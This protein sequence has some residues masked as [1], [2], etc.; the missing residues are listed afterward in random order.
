VAGQIIGLPEMS[1][2]DVVLTN[3]QIA[4]KEGMEIIH[5]KGIR[6]VDSKIT[7]ANG[8]AVVTHDAQVEGAG[9]E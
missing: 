3:V 2:S 9:S 4:A 8:P 6:F 1:I 7:A 5:A